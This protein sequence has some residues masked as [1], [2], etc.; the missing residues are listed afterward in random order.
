VALKEILGHSDIRVT[1]RYVH[2]RPIR[3]KPWRFTIASMSRLAGD[4][5]CSELDQNWIAQSTVA[6]RSS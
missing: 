4:K 3:T 2:V 6:G 5:C 1:M